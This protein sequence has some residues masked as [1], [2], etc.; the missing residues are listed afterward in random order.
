MEGNA[1]SKR[2]DSTKLGF[3]IPSADDP[4]MYNKVEHKN[5][6]KT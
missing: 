2:H 5:Q 6:N 4:N 3:F 1:N